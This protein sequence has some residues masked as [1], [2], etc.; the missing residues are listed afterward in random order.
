MNNNNLFGR[1]G[2]DPKVKYSDEDYVKYCRKVS[3]YPFINLCNSLCPGC[4]S[5]VESS[6]SE[7]RYDKFDV[8]IYFKNLDLSIT[9]N[10]KDVSLDYTA[11]KW[12][13]PRRSKNFTIGFDD[14]KIGKIDVF[15]FTE[16]I[17]NES[18]TEYITYPDFYIVSKSKINNLIKKGMLPL[19]NVDSPKPY[20]LCKLKYIEDNCIKLSDFSDLDK[21][22]KYFNIS[23]EYC[24]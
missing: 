2:L 17:L 23:G 9:G 10:I 15:I 21:V 1:P 14:I 18:E 7:D 13:D 20:Y 12:L 6:K 3:E 19:K 5:C 11:D 4:I 16:Y 22:K 24:E 8:K